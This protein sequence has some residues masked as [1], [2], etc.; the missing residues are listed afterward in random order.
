MVVCKDLV[1]RMY[2]EVTITNRLVFN[3]ILHRIVDDY[4][5]ILSLIL[6]LMVESE[7]ICYLNYHTDMERD[8]FWSTHIFI[9]ICFH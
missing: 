5:E 8:S 1:N 3:G 6:L 9:W 4:V 2:G 7:E